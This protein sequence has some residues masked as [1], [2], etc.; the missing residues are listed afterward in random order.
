MRE[1]LTHI[2][3]EVYKLV[4]ESE[5]MLTTDVPADLMGAVPHPINK[6]LVKTYKK[7]TSP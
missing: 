7:S 1:E 5:E 3:R 2:E 4:Q 6:G